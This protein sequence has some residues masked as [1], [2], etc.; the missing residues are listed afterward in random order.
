MVLWKP[1]LMLAELV[2]N[3]VWAGHGDAHHVV[4]QFLD[5]RLAGL[6][7][8]RE[9]LLQVA[10]LVVHVAADRAAGEPAADRAD[11]GAL[12]A[13]LVVG[14]RA[15]HRAADRAE[16]RALLAVAHAAERLVRGAAGERKNGDENGACGSCSSF[17][18][19]YGRFRIG[20]AENVLGDQPADLL[21]QRDDHLLA[22]FRQ[23]L[24]KFIQGV[25]R[26]LLDLVQLGKQLFCLH[27]CSVLRLRGQGSKRFCA[28]HSVVTARQSP[29]F[30]FQK[31]EQRGIRLFT[32]FRIGA[33]GH[34]F[35]AFHP[36]GTSVRTRTRVDG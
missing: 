14:D 21:H 28:L 1:D 18:H 9:V 33:D 20:A 5:A 32:R 6:D 3:A 12:G 11:H 31:F 34:A 4:R 2:S 23:V 19:A 13:V 7:L 29:Q 25:L 35:S 27:G 26:V 15:D 30:A 24:R 22:L 8:G 10:L 17:V 36:L 16:D